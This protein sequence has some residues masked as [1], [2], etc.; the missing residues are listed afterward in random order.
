MLSSQGDSGRGLLLRTLPVLISMLRLG[1]AREAALEG[2]VVSS[3]SSGIGVMSV[4][5][6]G[7]S[8]A[9]GVEGCGGVVG[10]GFPEMVVSARLL[11]VIGIVVGLSVI[12]GIASF[13]EVRVPV[14][15][16]LGSGISSSVLAG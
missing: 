6:L 16:A 8:S 9:D 4:V 1:A 15:G 5:E 2:G 3:A 14:A 11:E 12:V 13:L 7:Q 10:L